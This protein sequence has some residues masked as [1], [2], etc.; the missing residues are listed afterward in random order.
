MPH[1]SLLARAHSEDDA[2]AAMGDAVA[3]AV[4]YRGRPASRAATGGWKSS[5]FVMAMEIAER[6]A[7]KGVA[8]NLITYL[9]GPLGQPMARAAASI[10]AWKGVSQMLPL[11]VACVADAWLGRYRAIVLAS[12]LFV[13]SMGTLSLSS[14]FHIFRSGGHV[15]VFYVALYLVALGEGAHKPCAQAFAADQF[16]EKDPKENVARSSFFNWWY[17]GMCAGTAVTTMVS[18]YVQDNVGWGLGFGIPCIVILVSLAVF[19]IGTPSYRYYTTKEPSPVARVGKAL[20][21]LI[22]SWRSK[23]RTNPAS[24]KVEAHKNSDE[25]L[26]EEVSSVFRLLP[27]WA[28]C[29]IYAIIFSQ[30]STF[31]TKQAATLD[32]RIGPNFKVPPAALQTFISVSI[33]AFIPVYDRLFVPL[34]RRYTGRPTGITMLQ[35]VGAGLSLSLVAVVLSALVEMKRLAVARDAGLLDAP[36]A[37]H[38][39][40]TLW[41]MVPQYVL[42]GVSDVFAMIGLQEFFYDQVPDAVR[43]LGLALFLSIFGVGHLL[44]SFL[45]SVIDRATARRGAS[46]FSNNLNRAH[47]DY[48]YWLLAGLCVVELVAFFFFSRAYVYKK[49]SDDGDY[50][51]GDADA[52]LV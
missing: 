8:A 39:P 41:W 48:F 4:D 20:L 23:H 28:S 9:T 33:V 29:I 47:L 3:G 5:V 10:D 1:R 52:T 19:L 31:F 25:D 22:K 32:R 2:D 12:I 7:Y 17:F 37:S 11:P 34:A 18:S 43:S 16:D 15:A 27:I 42:I 36:K 24:G 50:R 6:F 21:V 38:L 40:M 35:R 30:T 44:S 46:W 26:V 13:V 51:G 49:K 14:A 45:I